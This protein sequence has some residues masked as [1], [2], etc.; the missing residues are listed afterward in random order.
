MA[1]FPAECRPDRK[2]DCRNYCQTNIRPSEKF[3]ALAESLEAK[4]APKWLDVNKADLSAKVV[5]FPARED[6]DFEF[7]EQLIV[8]LYSK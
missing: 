1:E 4:T 7:N 8:E 5:A 2:C 3:K 6:I